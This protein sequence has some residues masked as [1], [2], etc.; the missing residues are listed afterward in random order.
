MTQLK[1]IDPG[2]HWEP[3]KSVKASLAYCTKQETRA[4]RQYVFGIEVPEEVRVHEPRGWQLQVMEILKEEPDERVINWFWEAEGGVGKTALCKY[5]VMK[6][7]ALM[8]TGKSADM[9]YMLSKYPNKRK[10]IIVDC[11]RSLQDYFNYA[12]VEQIKNGLVFSGKYEG[13]QLCFNSPHVIVFGNR[14]PDRSQMS[15]DRWNVVHIEG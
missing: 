7:N 8:L 15:E 4:G 12:A 6:H 13:V 2:I 11:P 5:L 1:A 10:L 14:K 9:F 3:T